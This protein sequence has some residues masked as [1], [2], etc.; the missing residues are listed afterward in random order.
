MVKISDLEKLNILYV[1]DE[2]L[3]ETTFDT[4]TTLCK[5]V[6]NTKDEQEAM[7][8]YKNNIGHIDIVIVNI[9][10]RNGNSG[11]GIA[12]N[13]RFFNQNIP[14]VFIAKYIEIKDISEA[15]KLNIV[16][17]LQKPFSFN[18]LMYTLMLCVHKIQRA[19]NNNNILSYQILCENVYYC[20]LKKE[21]IINGRIIHLTKNEVATIEF[22]IE[23]KGTMIPYA[24][25]ANA[26]G[27]DISEIALMN[28]ISRLR[29]KIGI[30]NIKNVARL[31]YILL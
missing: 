28:I 3:V 31:G 21:V 7:D 4:L 22:L 12:R 2:I 29:K 8:V 27:D 1:D 20:V 14:I 26:I 11:I 5:N 30:C 15:I 9:Y 25:L 18:E 17:Y 24:V 19:N 23:K 13:I 10:L 16:N 6:Y